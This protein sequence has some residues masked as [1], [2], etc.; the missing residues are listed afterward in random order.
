MSEGKSGTSSTSTKT[1]AP[2]LTADQTAVRQLVTVVPEPRTA[3]E[4]ADRYA[5]LRIENQWPE[6]SA[7]SVKQ[8]I[9]ELIQK[10]FLKEGPKSPDGEPTNGA[11]VIEL[12][13]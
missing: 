10:G 6:Q 2:E 5:G 8:R 3:Q 12:A 11:P 4:L 9:G 1:K 7:S 13:D